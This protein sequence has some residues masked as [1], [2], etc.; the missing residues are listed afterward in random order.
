MVWKNYTPE[1]N[2]RLEI[3]GQLRMLNIGS[4]DDI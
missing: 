1:D 2:I 4:L 3:Y